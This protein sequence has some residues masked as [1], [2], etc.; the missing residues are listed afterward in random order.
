MSDSMS[1]LNDLPE[2]VVS[3]ILSWLPV[4]SLLQA[5]TVCKFWKSIISNPN[6]SKLHVDHS[7]I[8]KNTSI[9][10]HNFSFYTVLFHRILPHYPQ[11]AIICRLPMP[12][13]EPH[14]HCSIDGIIC[15]SCPR[16]EAISLWNPSIKRCKWLPVPLYGKDLSNQVDVSLGFGFDS[17]SR[18]YKVVR[19]LCCEETS[20]IL[21]EL[22]SAN[23][24][25]WRGIQVR[26]QLSPLRRGGC[27]V[28]VKDVLYWLSK[29]GLSLV[30]FDLR[31]QVFGL[32]PL[33]SCVQ[34]GIFNVEFVDFKDSIAMIVGNGE[35]SSL[36]TM[37]NV[38]GE[39]SWTKKFK[40]E[41]RVF[42]I[43]QCYEHLRSGNYVAAKVGGLFFYD[44]GSESFTNATSFRGENWR[45]YNY[46]ESLVSFEG[47]VD[48]A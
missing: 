21:V 43:S 45:F 2:G 32:I 9:I 38:H 24:N 15:L 20:K 39:V 26:G 23:A 7:A 40:Y 42:D 17:R 1:S 31:R 14:I 16:I 27:E 44:D 37:D 3:E 22:Y 5:R 34:Q 10:L 29:D 25:S 33:P 28:C 19:I 47:S 41:A 35:G 46:T 6:F 18:D 8:S 48:V 11:K 12:Y 13:D 36:W 30:S 4:K